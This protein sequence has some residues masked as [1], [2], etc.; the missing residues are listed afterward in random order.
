MKQAKPK[1]EQTTLKRDKKL[2]VGFFSIVT[3]LGGLSL[4]K[5][6]LSFKDLNEITGFV[7][8]TSSAWEYEVASY[9]CIEKW[10]HKKAEISKKQDHE[11]I[12]QQLTNDVNKISK[13]LDEDKPIIELKPN[14]WGFALNLHELT[15]RIKKLVKK[16]RSD[17]QN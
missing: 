13:I 12:I 11:N 14:F 1:K 5:N 15:D 2:N 16:N 9:K 7:L 17:Q 4:D 8:D 10:N 3:A 6:N